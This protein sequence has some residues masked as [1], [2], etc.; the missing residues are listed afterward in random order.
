MCGFWLLILYFFLGGNYKGIFLYMVFLVLWCLGF[1]LEWCFVGFFVLIWFF[2]L[3]FLVG[4]K[5]E[6]KYWVYIFEG[7]GGGFGKGGV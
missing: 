6:G 5:R 3:V 4:S 1:V 2:C 7:L